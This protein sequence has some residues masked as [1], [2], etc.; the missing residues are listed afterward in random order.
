MFK[1]LFFASLLT[2]LFLGLPAY[3][4]EDF[5]AMS[6]TVQI[7]AH[8]QLF[9]GD[10][11]HHGSGSGT[12]I[13]E[14]GLILT[15]HHVIFD[16][17]E[18]EPLE[19]FE[20]CLTFNTEKEPVCQYMARLVA[21]DKDLDI[22]LLQLIN[23]DVFD[24]P[25][26]DLPY[27]NY[28]N[29]VTLKEQ[30]D[31]R[32]NGYPASGGNTIT[33][34]RGQI[35]G[36]EKFNGYR[37]FKTDTDF[38]HGSSGGTAL[39]LNGNFIGIPTYIRSYA[40]NVG[41]F[42]D[43]KEAWPWIE[44]N[45]KKKPVEHPMA[46]KE[47]KANM[48]R[49]KQANDRL[50]YEQD[51]YPYL[52]VELP[53][54][55]EFLEVSDD[56]IFA[57]QKNLSHPVGF[58]LYTLPYLFEINEDYL[59][60]LDEELE[61]VRQAFPDY[62]KEAVRFGGED[63]WKIT[64]TSLSN[65]N[66]TY[67]IPYGYMLIGLS[68]SLE[69]DRADQQEKMMNAAMEGIA[70]TS[71]S[72]SEPELPEVIHF[73]NPDFSIRPAGDWRLRPNSSRRSYDLLVE[74]AEQDNYEGSFGLFYR[75][76]SRDERV[77]SSKGRLAEIIK[78][79]DR[80]KLLYQNDEVTLGGL[81]GFLYTYEYEGPEYQEIR[82]NLVIH[83]RNDLYEFI[84][85]YDDLAEH[86][87]RSL[88][89]VKEML[90][91]FSFKGAAGVVDLPNQYGDLG[92]T[93]TDIQNHRYALPIGALASK[94][95][96]AGDKEGRF[97][98]ENPAGRGEAMKWI[99]ESKNHLENEKQSKKAIDFTLFDKRAHTDA[100]LRRH[101]DRVYAYYG[102]QMGYISRQSNFRPNEPI[103]L[104]EALKVILSAYE[105]PVWSGETEPWFKKYMD[106][107]FELRLIPYG[108]YNPSHPLTRAELAQLIYAIYEQAK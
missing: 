92:Y 17:D 15:N 31:I 80:E 46:E 55:W 106:K 4:A 108:M 103:K 81:K 102:Q 97:F 39:D 107:G 26:P 85:D 96:L 84:I 82:K 44:K 30:T 77:L 12:V 91:S 7:K 79:F 63:A 11:L 33:T 66:T 98:P 13:S 24:Q 78:R 51:Q 14:D 27:L 40:E 54:G 21:H 61:R 43:L 10:V 88:P 105:V 42:L 83:L 53:D 29:D 2:S 28:K 68:Y 45:L 101:P 90:D 104:A 93:F 67:Y 74:G 86:F 37:Y 75:L 49:F 72:R 16:E 87:D 18:F 35:S 25:I 65:K 19:A 52:K 58:N 50:I 47:L 1:R 73:K 62:K 69:I 89:S 48:R 6:P 70:F 41:Y 36:F 71:S 56:G 38:D 34:T 94:K 64:Y 23:Q 59:D 8:K 99:F 9:I 20:V 5:N 95:I 100:D 22:A 60:Q 32:V 76:I 3:A 57:S